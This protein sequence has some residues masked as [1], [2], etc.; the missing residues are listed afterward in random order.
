MVCNVHTP[1]L[2]TLWCVVWCGVVWCDVVW[3]GVVLRGERER[4]GCA[5]RL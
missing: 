1:H 3:C 4:G 2:V 5:K